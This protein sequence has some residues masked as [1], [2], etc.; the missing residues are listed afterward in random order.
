MKKLGWVCAFGLAGVVLTICAEALAGY[1]VVQNSYG[2]GDN[3]VTF[4]QLDPK[5]KLTFASKTTT[6]TGPLASFYQLDNPSLRD[7]LKATLSGRKSAKRQSGSEIDLAYAQFLKGKGILEQNPCIA[8]RPVTSPDPFE[9]NA[10]SQ[11]TCQSFESLMEAAEALNDSLRALPNAWTRLY[12]GMA[13]IRMRAFDLGR[14]ELAVAEKELRHAGQVGAADFAKGYRTTAQAWKAGGDD[15]FMRDGTK[16]TCPTTPDKPI[17]TLGQPLSM[18][19]LLFCGR[20]TGYEESNTRSQTIL[21]VLDKTLDG[22]HGM[23]GRRIAANWGF[24]CAMRIKDEKPEIQDRI[25]VALLG[26]AQRERYY[27]NLADVHLRLFKRLL[28]SGRTNDA[29]LRLSSDLPLLRSQ[30]SVSELALSYVTNRAIDDSLLARLLVILGFDQAQREPYLRLRQASKELQDSLEILSDG[31][32]AYMR[33]ASVDNRYLNFATLAQLSSEQGISVLKEKFIAA[34]KDP[35]TRKTLLAEIRSF[36]FATGKYWLSAPKRHHE[37]MASSERF[38]EAFFILASSKESPPRLRRMADVWKS[39]QGE[40]K[41]AIGNLSTQLVLSG[42]AEP[43]VGRF[44]EAI[45]IYIPFNLMSDIQDAED[46]RAELIFFQAAIDLTGIL[47]DA[48][49]NNGKSTERLTDTF[50]KILGIWTGD[51]SE[52]GKSIG[53]V[54]RVCEDNAPRTNLC[55]SATIGLSRSVSRILLTLGG[56]WISRQVLDVLMNRVFQ[57]MRMADVDEATLNRLFV[58]GVNS[59][60]SEALDNR[61][62]ITLSTNERVF[63]EMLHGLISNRSNVLM[64]DKA[65]EPGR[66]LID[67]IAFAIVS[68]S[69]PEFVQDRLGFIELQRIRHLVPMAFMLASPKVLASLPLEKIAPAYDHLALLGGD[70]GNTYQ[71]LAAS[72]A[73]GFTKQDETVA[74][75]LGYARLQAI[76]AM[77]TTPLPQGLRV[78][79]PLKSGDPWPLVIGAIEPEPSSTVRNQIDFKIS[80]LKNSVYSCSAFV[81]IR[82]ELTPEKMKQVIQPELI[83]LAAKENACDL[84][85]RTLDHLVVSANG[86]PR[87]EAMPDIVLR[88][89]AVAAAEVLKRKD[90]SISIS[91]HAQ[92]WADHLRER[93]E[94][95]PRDRI[96]LLRGMFTGQRR[97][98]DIHFDLP[99]GFP[100]EQVGA[101]IAALGLAPGV[102]L[103]DESLLLAAQRLAEARICRDAIYMLKGNILEVKIVD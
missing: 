92:L 73:I 11:P 82:F 44:I 33:T 72:L 39:H 34:I 101:V 60:I 76:A 74:D 86:N 103:T 90:C 6:Y 100:S 51:W 25:D 31:M 38:R 88:A 5:F 80:C 37:L 27:E 48:T 13:H 97:L 85:E 45:G 7:W 66:S 98:D 10:E 14:D 84:L 32:T 8:L 47:L 79:L 46:Y 95:E 28:V 40:I 53:E 94:I 26:F 65:I 56:E 68:V 89:Y 75:Q 35:D 96:P 1:A 36:L 29:L 93:H 22:L 9:S 63:L 81:D 70:H 58:Q 55:R 2:H 67:D 30:L 62:P 52:I 21:A 23:G 57:H 17:E 24:Q 4:D 3:I 50:E 54:I 59:A 42:I 102:E 71:S 69:R 91:L 43:E 15:I 16:F 18:C 78:Q 83:R 64:K 12:Q 49:R 19:T 41:T 77:I 61:L 99:K 87:L 20:W